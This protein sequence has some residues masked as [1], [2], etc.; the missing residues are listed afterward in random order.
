MHSKVDQRT[1]TS[2]V[3]KFVLGEIRI[4]ADADFIFQVTFFDISRSGFALPVSDND[5]LR[6]L[7]TVAVSSNGLGALVSLG[8]IHVF[9]LRLDICISHGSTC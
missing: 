6:S 5:A 8:C 4:L 1:A 2:L 9:E 7:H 3:A